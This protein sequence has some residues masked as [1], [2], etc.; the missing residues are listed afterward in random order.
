MPAGIHRLASTSSALA[1]PSTHPCSRA[2][3]TEVLS[4]LTEKKG[5]WGREE[6]GK[7]ICP[8]IAAHQLAGVHRG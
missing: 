7:E 4:L 6:I 1:R 3:G 5:M 2:I 8:A